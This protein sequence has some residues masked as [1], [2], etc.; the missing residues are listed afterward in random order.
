M[1]T[2]DGGNKMIL[3][4]NV[5]KGIWNRMMAGRQL[6]QWC[7]ANIAIQ[8]ERFIRG[9]LEVYYWH[10][11]T[12]WLDWISSCKGGCC[13]AKPLDS[14]ATRQQPGSD[15]LTCILPCS[16]QSACLA[17]LLYVP[18]NAD[19]EQKI[20]PTCCRDASF[21]TLLQWNHDSKLQFKCSQIVFSIRKKLWIKLHRLPVSPS[22]KHS[23]TLWVAHCL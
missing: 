10:L 2:K 15:I 22:R 16:G 11:R 8:S 18:V 9:L 14:T 19:W 13:F 5:T 3:D 17:Q 23:E 7:C 21:P 20:E 6:G 4:P 1:E 12:N